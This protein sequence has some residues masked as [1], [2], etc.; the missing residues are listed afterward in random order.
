MLISFEPNTLKMLN[1]IEM[2]SRITFLK[3]LGK[4]KKKREKKKEKKSLG[5]STTRYGKLTVLFSYAS[6]LNTNHF[7]FGKLSSALEF[8]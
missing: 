2:F 7:L 1:N 5:S 3:S 4:K 6:F 8:C